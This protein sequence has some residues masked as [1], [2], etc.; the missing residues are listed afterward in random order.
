MLPVKR[1]FSS[2]DAARAIACC[3]AIA[4]TLFTA[5]ASVAVSGVQNVGDGGNVVSPN[6]VKVREGL[7]A[8]ISGRKIT[9]LPGY[10]WVDDTLVQIKQARIVEQPVCSSQ[11]MPVEQLTFAKDFAG[12]EVAV[13]SACIANKEMKMGV[14]DVLTPQSLV[15]KS[16]ADA[17]SRT[18][19]PGKDYAVSTAGAVTKVKGGALQSVKSCYATYSVNMH[20]VDSIAIDDSGNLRFATGKPAKWAAVPPLVP[21]DFLPLYNVYSY[22]GQ[23][24]GQDDVVGVSGE[25]AAITLTKLRDHNRE[26]LKDT[27]AKLKQGKSVKIA[28]WGDSITYGTGAS[29]VDK[30][31]VS[32]FIKRLKQKFPQAQITVDREGLANAN[33]SLRGGTFYQDV[34]SK[35]PDL[36]IVEFLNDMLFPAVSA[37]DRYVQF[38]KAIKIIHADAM[39]IAPHLPDPNFV[40]E[41]GVNG[42]GSLTYCDMLRSLWKGDP[43]MALCDVAAR[44]EHLP[45]EGLKRESLLVDGVHPSDRGHEIYAEELIKVFQ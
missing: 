6:S 4:A 24:I 33:T 45:Q 44:W 19:M 27:L 28:I 10:C 13:L 16:G 40:A 36:V 32:V 20:R 12:H 5:P 37:S 25:P 14:G 26:A 31:Y 41:R 3:A 29:S 11:S 22:T 8:Q 7:A 39:I 9:I 1:Q 23:S 43:T 2:T 38:I 17:H 18:Y 42:N 34:L 35:S 21:Q 15:L 30:S